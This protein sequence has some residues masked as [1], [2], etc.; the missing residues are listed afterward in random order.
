MKRRDFF[1][2]MFVSVAGILGLSSVAKPKQDELYYD[3]HDGNY[4]K[5]KIDSPPIE[6]T[7]WTHVAIAKD[8]TASST[9]YVDGKVTYRM[10]WNRALSDVEIAKLASNPFCMCNKEQTSLWLSK[11]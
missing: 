10:S 11:K 2:K 7:K 9:V 5:L 4:N 6:P 3:N 1:K 8:H